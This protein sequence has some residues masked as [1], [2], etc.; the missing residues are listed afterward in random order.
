[1]DS[2]TERHGMQR[3]VV[4]AP[5][6]HK[7]VTELNQAAAAAMGTRAGWAVEWLGPSRVQVVDE[8][9]DLR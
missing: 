5:S 9:T 8:P 2:T 3:Y 7:R 1:M 4:Y 6:G